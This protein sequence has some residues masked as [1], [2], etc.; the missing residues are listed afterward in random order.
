MLRDAWPNWLES[1]WM[2]WQQ[3]GSARGSG[4][5]RRRCRAARVSPRPAPNQDPGAYWMGPH[6]D[7]TSGDTMKALSLLARHTAEC[8]GTN[9]PTS[10]I[11]PGRIALD[12]EAN[13]GARV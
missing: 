2:S 6:G 4:R 8:P 7:G 5:Q 9:P 10:P 13:S 3:A 11:R 12:T 1:S